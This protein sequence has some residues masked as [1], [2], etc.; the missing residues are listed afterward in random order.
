[1]NCVVVVVDRE[2]WR[3]CVPTVHLLCAAPVNSPTPLGRGSRRPCREDMARTDPGHPRLCLT[4]VLFTRPDPGHHPWADLSPLPLPGK[5]LGLGLP[6]CPWL[7]S[8]GSGIGRPAG[9]C[10]D[11]PMEVR[12]CPTGSLR[13]LQHLAVLVF[14]LWAGV[15]PVSSIR[16]TQ[17][18]GTCTWVSWPTYFGK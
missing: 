13:P 8:C 18:W 5:C 10:P 7:P 11:V 14:L 1:M 12:H 9:P 4:L 15:S 6:H 17:E 16:D 3:G 2:L